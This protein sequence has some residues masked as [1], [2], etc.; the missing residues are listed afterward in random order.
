MFLLL[1]RG[2]QGTIENQENP[3]GTLE[4]IRPKMIKKEKNFC[5]DHTLKFDGKQAIRNFEK[6][7][8]LD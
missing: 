7:L 6:N 3:Y 5:L 8:G 2:N 4:T 1:T